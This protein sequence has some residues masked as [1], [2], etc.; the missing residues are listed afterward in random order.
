V[1]IVA[2]PKVY[3]AETLKA[4]SE[5]RVLAW[6]AVGA[7]GEIIAQDDDI[8]A[9]ADKMER[10]FLETAERFELISSE[11]LATVGRPEVHFI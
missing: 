3:S 10:R 1:T 5:G 8:D 7:C 11:R 9:L 2:E 6:V 4:A